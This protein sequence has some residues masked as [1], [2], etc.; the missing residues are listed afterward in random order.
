[1]GPGC[2]CCSSKS[3]SSLPQTTA[4]ID[5]TFPPPLCPLPLCIVHSLI[6]AH[7]PFCHH[8][9][10]PVSTILHSCASFLNYRSSFIV[11]QL[12]WLAVFLISKRMASA[13]VVIAS[14]SHRLPAVVFLFFLVGPKLQP[15]VLLLLYGAKALP[16]HPARGSAW[17]VSNESAKASGS[18]L[19]MLQQKA[20]CWLQGLA[21][22]A[23]QRH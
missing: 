23:S 6:P 7:T 5:H 4:T 12:S 20:P 10:A 9:P 19:R 17:H 16:A 3:A 22:A 14:V 15:Y 11:Q 8:P 13:N 18:R 2:G 1:M 21:R